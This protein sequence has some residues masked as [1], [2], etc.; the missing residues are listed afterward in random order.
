ML[1]DGSGFQFCKSAPQTI[2]CIVSVC[3]YFI[4]TFP[5]IT[6]TVDFFVGSMRNRMVEC[7][8]ADR[9]I[10]IARGGGMTCCM[11][12]AIRM[13]SSNLQSFEWFHSCHRITFLICVIHVAIYTVARSRVPVHICEYDKCSVDC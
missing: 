2:P 11:M 9:T 13:C 7:I 12:V 8:R 10:M 4:K 1:A 6:I 3:V 5:T